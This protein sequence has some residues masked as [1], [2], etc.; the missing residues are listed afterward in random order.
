MDGSFAGGDLLGSTVEGADVSD[1]VGLDCVLRR[2]GVLAI[3]HNPWDI[4]VCGD[5]AL[6]DLC[7]LHKVAH[8]DLGGSTDVDSVPIE[9]E[10]LGALLALGSPV[11]GVGLEA[12]DEGQ[13][14]GV[15]VV[16]L[17]SAGLN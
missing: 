11:S 1:H 17:Q 14:L 7:N 5:Q 10:L 3:H 13:G 6:S 16:E 9:G 8:A 2:L 12:D 15:P 4:G